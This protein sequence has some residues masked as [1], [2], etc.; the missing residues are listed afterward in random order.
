MVL[1][2]CFL[3]DNYLNRN[4]EIWLIDLKL[5]EGEVKW[6]SEDLLFYSFI[7]GWF[8]FLECLFRFVVGYDKEYGCCCVKCLWI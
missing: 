7:Y 5:R 8:I 1:S 6:K 3:K 4:V 2:E